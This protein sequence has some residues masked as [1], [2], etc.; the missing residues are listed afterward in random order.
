[1]VMVTAR[2]TAGV[3]VEIGPIDVD[4]LNDQYTALVDLIAD[5]QKN[6]LWGV[7]YMIGDILQELDSGGWGAGRGPPNKTITKDL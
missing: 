3:S 6:I 2:G 5:D 1:M 4:I 7:V